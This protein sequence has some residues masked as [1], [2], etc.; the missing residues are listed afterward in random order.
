MPCTPIRFCALLILLAMSAPARAA[1]NAVLRTW[2]SARGET[3]EAMFVRLRAGYV[4]LR[5]AEGKDLQIRLSHLT[6]A[7]QTLARQLANPPQPEPKRKTAARAGQYK[8]TY[9]SGRWKGKLDCVLSEDDKGLLAASFTAMHSDGKAHR[10]S[11]TLRPASGGKYNG[12]FDVRR[13]KEFRVTGSF[14][15]DKFTATLALVGRN[16]RESKAGKFSM[17]RKEPE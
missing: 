13:P 5:T 15:G 16:G 3:V 17:S 14:R 8:G 12:L 11:G 10:Y 4:V 6:R 2:T 7:D 1:T 9:H